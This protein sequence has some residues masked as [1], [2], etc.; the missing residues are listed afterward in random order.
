MS[1]VLF[2]EEEKNTTN[3][4]E[5]TISLKMNLK[6]V[7][8][9]ILP[10]IFH[11]EVRKLK[12]TTNISLCHA[13]APHAYCHLCS[14]MI[15]LVVFSCVLCFCFIFRLLILCILCFCFILVFFFSRDELHTLLPCLTH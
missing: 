11:L 6:E 8:R 13:F 4:F 9:P 5:N 15:F 2:K 7:R 12:R 10:L 3:T 14:S 1:L